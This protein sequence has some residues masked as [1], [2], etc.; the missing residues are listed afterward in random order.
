MTDA[1]CPKCAAHVAEAALWCGQC[2][3]SLVKEPV[4]PARPPISSD[5]ALQVVG[6]GVGSA[7]AGPSGLPS[8]VPPP[9]PGPP[10]SIPPPPAP[11]GD[12]PGK[13]KLGKQPWPCMRCETVNPFENNS[14]SACG[15][16]FLAGLSEP[17]ASIP[18]IGS[19]DATTKGGRFKIGLIASG[20]LMFLLLTV[21]TVAGLILH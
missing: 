5:K 2:Y 9:P 6:A 4:K 15:Q 3:T 7:G 12:A 1:R 13:L 11:P 8:D 19:I 16:G 21:F 17:A 20:V 10:G 18:L 14:C